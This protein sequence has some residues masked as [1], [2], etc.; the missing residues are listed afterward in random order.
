MVL[1][2]KSW[3][4]ITLMVE[5]SVNIANQAGMCFLNIT[6][7]K[8]YSVQYLMLYLMYKAQNIFGAC[9][10]A[11]N[12]MYVTSLPLQPWFEVIN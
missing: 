6:I 10:C 1:D 12:Y 7:C 3:H 2:M 8:I 4:E 9:G 11:T 5:R